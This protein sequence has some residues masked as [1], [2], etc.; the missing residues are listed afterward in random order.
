[1]DLE[2]SQIKINKKKKLH[3][4][5][6]ARSCKEAFMLS[7]IQVSNWHNYPIEMLLTGLCVYGLRARELGAS[8]FRI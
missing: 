2:T 4:I 8:P 6:K 3:K 5:I 1:M 7:R